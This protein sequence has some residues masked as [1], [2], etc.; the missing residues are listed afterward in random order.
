M[1]R[2]YKFIPRCGYN[3][4]TWYQT[5]GKIVFDADWQDPS[6]DHACSLHIIALPMLC[7]CGQAVQQIK[8]LEAFI[9]FFIVLLVGVSKSCIKVY[10]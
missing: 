6:F 9:L 5:F 7:Q 4:H 3:W 8:I 1:M 10:P 2:S